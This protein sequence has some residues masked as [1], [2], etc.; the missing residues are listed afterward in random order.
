MTDNTKKAKLPD[1]K[2]IALSLSKNVDKLSEQEQD[3]I[4]LAICDAMDDGNDA[5]FSD[6]LREIGDNRATIDNLAM[7]ADAACVGPTEIEGKKLFAWAFVIGGTLWANGQDTVYRLSEHSSLTK[8][9]QSMFSGSGFTARI[10]PFLYDAYLKTDEIVSPGN[11]HEIYNSMDEIFSGNGESPKNERDSR[12]PEAISPQPCNM[13]LILTS[14][15]AD[16]D[17]W[18][19][20]DEIDQKTEGVPFSVSYKIGDAIKDGTFEVRYVGMPVGSFIDNPYHIDTESFMEQVVTFSGTNPGFETFITSENEGDGFIVHCE[21]TDDG[22][23]IGRF[24]SDFIMQPWL[25]EEEM[26]HI[27]LVNKQEF[28]NQSSDPF[29]NCSPTIH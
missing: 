16:S 5:W 19:A 21:F 26:E 27:L 10:A 28:I 18:Q 6:L 22:E 12:A 11:L 25:L 1:A 2:S 3:Q 17:P 9:V 20:L 24:E 23:T 7:F 4:Q 15:N 29:A 13:V 8:E 14:E